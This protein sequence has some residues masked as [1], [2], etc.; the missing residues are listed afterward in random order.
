MIKFLKSSLGQSC[1]IAPLILIGMIILLCFIDAAAAA[2]CKTMEEYQKEYTKCYAC[3]T[4]KL[5]LEAFMIAASRTYEISKDAGIILLTIGSFLWVPFF[6]IG[7][8][9][10]FTNPEGPK[11]VNEFLIFLFKVAFAYVAINVGISVLVDY[12]IN[13]IL[14]A[15]A[16]MGTAYLSFGL[17]APD[18]VEGMTREY[19]FDGDPATAIINPAVIDKI[20]DFTEGVTIK[21]SSNMVIGNALM[22][23]SLDAFKL[24]LGIRTVD[25][26]LWLCGAAIWVIGFLLA[27]FVCYY[28][29]DICFKIG[30]AIIMLPIAIGLWPFKAT[31]GRVGACFSIILRS[32]AIYAML[33]VCTTLATI[34][35]DAVLDVDKLFEYIE[36]DNI[37]A[38]DKMFSLFSAGFDNPYTT[39]CR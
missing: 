17:P 1:K 38:I 39:R 2:E 24:I 12:F 18:N 35:I 6:V 32:A 10:S 5:M 15:G 13:P 30:F 36:K 19:R 7:K 14:A 3:Q 29:L 25:I 21:V 26:W 23:H 4:V 28:L 8:I 22:C 34:L 11:M 31:K 37:E 20:L 27:L 16:D 9:S 33:A